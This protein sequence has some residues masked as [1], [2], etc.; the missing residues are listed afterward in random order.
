VT[1]LRNR[2]GRNQRGSN[3]SRNRDFVLPPSPR[4]IVQT[5]S[6]ST[7]PLP[8]QL[9]QPEFEAEHTSM[10][11]HAVHPFVFFFSTAP[12]LLWARASSLLTL[13]DQTLRHITLSRTPLD[14]WSARRRGLYLTTH[15]T[16]KRQ[17]SMAPRRNSNPQSQ[18]ANSRKP[19][20]ETALPLGSALSCIQ[21]HKQP[22]DTCVLKSKLQI[23]VSACMKPS[24]GCR[25]LCKEKMYN[26][27]AMVSLTPSSV[28]EI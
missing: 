5:E 15:N 27:I 8:L 19:T 28:V 10:W 22:S 2:R 13:H 24:W 14:K 26:C 23:R 20:S 16:Q 11:M 4:Q 9:K 18:Q 1:G 6:R 25:S 12:H 21:R 3:R 17:T 7:Q